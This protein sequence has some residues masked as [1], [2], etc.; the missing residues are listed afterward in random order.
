MIE[1]YGLEILWQ[2]DDGKVPARLSRTWLLAL[3]YH[4]FTISYTH[5]AN[6]SLASNQQFLVILVLLSSNDSRL[7]Y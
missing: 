2:E 4:A 5:L 7:L 1:Y 6:N 3:T